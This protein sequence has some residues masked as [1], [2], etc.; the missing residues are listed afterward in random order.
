VGPDAKCWRIPRTAGRRV[1]DAAATDGRSAKLTRVFKPA[2]EK[3]TGQC[4]KAKLETR[5]QCTC[6]CG[7]EFHGQ[8]SPDWTPVGGDLLARR[9]AGGAITQTTHNGIA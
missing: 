1:Y 8:S 9:G 3:C 2:T 7:G 4:Q 5:D 6:I